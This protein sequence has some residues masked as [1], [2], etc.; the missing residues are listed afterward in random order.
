MTESYPPNNN[1]Y[2][3]NGN[4]YD[5][6]HQA[7]MMQPTPQY[8]QPAGSPFQDGNQNGYYGNNNNQG[9]SQ[10]YGNKVDKFDAVKPK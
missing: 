1:G 9:W 4:N 7:P 8:A 5:G 3:Q 6:K 10:D 2:Q